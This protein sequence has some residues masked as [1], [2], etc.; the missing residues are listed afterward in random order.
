MTGVSLDT[1][2]LANIAHR[3]EADHQSQNPATD[4]PKDLEALEVDD[5]A[6]TMQPVGDTITHF[7]GELSYWNF[8][9]R[10]K[11]HIESQIQEHSQVLVNM[12]TLQRLFHVPIIYVFDTVTFFFKFTEEYLF[13]V[14]QGWI[15]E[16]LDVLYNRPRGLEQAGWDVTVS[17]L[18]T[19]LAIGTQYA[20]L[21][22]VK[23]TSMPGFPEEEIGTMF[24]EQA[25]RLL[26]EIIEVSSLESVQ[27]CLLFGYYS[28]PIDA[29]G[30]GFVYINLAM[31]LA[32]QNGM[33]RKCHDTTFSAIVIKTR[34]QI[35]W[36]TYVLERYGFT[37]MH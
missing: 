1:K 23:G 20:H 34:N 2:N 32:I 26:P 10:I 36:T 30:L 4:D 8:S 21:E 25:I 6:C 31:R 13:F 14:D 17:I 7:S 18:L 11:S 24:Y 33:H 9:M 35:W 29:S 15:L 16:K 3:L 19:V 5:E 12:M 28:L 37:P 22:R 27:A